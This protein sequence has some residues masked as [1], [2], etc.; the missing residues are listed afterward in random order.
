MDAVQF[1]LRRVGEENLHY[2]ESDKESSVQLV[3]VPGG[4]NP[5]LWK[6]Q[7]R[8]FSK[9][10]RTISFKP[11][12]SFRDLS[13]ERSALENV[14]NQ[15]HLDNV[16]LVS[17]T[18]G[19]SLVQEFEERDDVISTVLTG[20]RRKFEKMPPRKV[21]DWFYRIGKFRPK[22]AKKLF[23]SDDTK[24]KV[25][26]DFMQTLEKPDYSDFK[27]FLDNYKVSRPSKQSL[28]IHAGDDRFSDL[29][30]AR[31]L[32]PN[33]SLS[34]LDAAGTFSFFE[35]PQDFNKA[36]I[37]FIGIVKDRAETE[38]FMEIKQK[39]RSLM[40]FEKEDE[41]NKESRDEDESQKKFRKE[42]KKVKV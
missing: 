24:Y 12:V 31:E 28:V 4:L 8:Y 37:D 34:K 3:F 42:A 11:T 40:E 36:L 27:S 33:A 25:V 15:D 30:F 21:L 39:N 5:E 2:Y 38:K 18:F 6:Q 1:S 9:R 35:K 10:F 7:I 23:F 20:P 19:N 17:N 22:I 16:I 32:E 14:L 13:G 41:E 29:D 26:K